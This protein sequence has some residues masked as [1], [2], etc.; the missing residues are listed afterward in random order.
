MLARHWRGWTAPEDADAYERLLTDDLL[1][2]FAR[3]A[4]DGLR[5]YELGRRAA[6]E[7]VAFATTIYFDSRAAVEAFAGADPERAHVPEPARALLVRWEETA[8]HYEVR[9]REP[10]QLQGDG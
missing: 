8:T 6:G 1:P 5:G 3:E 7:E 4:G 2:R 10:P 9:A